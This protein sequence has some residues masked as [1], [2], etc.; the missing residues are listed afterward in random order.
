VEAIRA[1]FPESAP[2][3]WGLIRGTVH[4]LP[5]TVRKLR[6]LGIYDGKVYPGTDR[7]S[8]AVPPLLVPAFEAH[9]RMTTRDEVVVFEGQRFFSSSILRA[10]AKRFPGSRFFLLTAS[11]SELDRRRAARSDTKGRTFLKAAATQSRNAVLEVP[12]VCEVLTNDTLAD[13]ERN[14][15]KLLSLITG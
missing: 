15:N 10:A 9:D 13:L 12:D 2:F 3:H 14:I 7:L 1:Q 8:M 5:G 6:V 11:E 4:G